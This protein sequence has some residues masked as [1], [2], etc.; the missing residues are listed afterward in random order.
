MQAHRSGTPMLTSSGYNA[1]VDDDLCIGCAECNSYC[2]FHALSILD[3]VNHV[4]LEL[5]MGCGVCVSH[6]TEG[7]I[8][9]I[10]APEKGIPL[11]MSQILESL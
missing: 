5:C 11:E 6:C 2:Q 8:E 10:L 4:N 7:A 9:L 3:G 1:L